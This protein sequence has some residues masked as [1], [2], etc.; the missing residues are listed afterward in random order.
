MRSMISL[1]SFAKKNKANF[2]ILSDPGGTIAEK[3]EVLRFG[4]FASRTTFIIDKE[5]KI[6]HI[7]ANVNPAFAGKELR[8]TLEKMK[9]EKIDE[10]L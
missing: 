4:T 3:Y 10:Q 7:D 5:G 1:V 8:N 6:I 2:P 9:Q